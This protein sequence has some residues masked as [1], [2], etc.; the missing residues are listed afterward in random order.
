V[1]LSTFASATGTKRILSL[2]SECSLVAIKQTP[3][4]Q[5]GRSAFDPERSASAWSGFALCPFTEHKRVAQLFWVEH[6]LGDLRAG[7]REAPDCE[8]AHLDKDRR[9]IP[10]DMLVG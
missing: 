1:P 4:F 10:I 3:Q 8:Q 2:P 7:D 6:L 9:L 5:G